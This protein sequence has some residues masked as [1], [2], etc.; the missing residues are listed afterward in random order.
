MEAILG[1]RIDGKMG[2][3][4]GKDGMVLKKGRWLYIIGDRCGLRMVCLRD[5]R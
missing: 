3:E 4:W 2:K 5:A 1:G